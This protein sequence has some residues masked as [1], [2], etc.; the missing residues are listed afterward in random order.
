[1]W[2]TNSVDADKLTSLEEGQSG[3]ILFSK[4]GKSNVVV[5][6]C[7]PLRWPVFPS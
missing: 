3:S 4:V 6:I 1:M 5:F 7:M 2:V